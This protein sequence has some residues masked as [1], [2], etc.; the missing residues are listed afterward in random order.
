MI[1]KSAV[2]QLLLLDM[3]V[4]SLIAFS[5]FLY[6]LLYIFLHL[7]C[8]TQFILQLAQHFIST[9]KLAVDCLNFSFSLHK[10][11][12]SR[13]SPIHCLKW[14]FPR[15]DMEY[16]NKTIFPFPHV[17]RIQNNRFRFLYSYI[18]P[19]IGSSRIV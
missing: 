19:D 1:L 3:D 10:S 15:C 6:L 4:Y 14:S 13:F 17:V 12:H 9:E 16:G 8:P 2:S 5:W 11:D 18:L 7:F